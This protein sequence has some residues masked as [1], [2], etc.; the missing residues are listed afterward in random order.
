MIENEMLFLGLLMDGPKHGYEI[1]R[2]I[3]EE[4]FPF[5][6]LKVKS[7][8]Y[9]LKKMEKLGLIDKDVGR[10]GKWPEKFIYR[11]TPKGE[12]IF[13]HLVTESFLSIERPFFNIDLSV[14]FLQYVD[15]MIAQRKLKGRLISLRRIKRN[16]ESFLDKDISQYPRHLGVILE[17]DLELTKAEIKSTQR[18]IDSLGTLS[19]ARPKG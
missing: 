7:I 18:L 14:Y 10:E 11:I 17:H 16:I 19:S 8:Y 15:P 4:L 2:K 13:R 9:P 1:K 12:K 6:G 3:D 5:V